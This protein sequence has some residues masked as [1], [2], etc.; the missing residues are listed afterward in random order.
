MSTVNRE[1]ERFDIRSNSIDF[2]DR[3]LVELE[4]RTYEMNRVFH[5]LILLMMQFQFV[6]SIKCDSRCGFK[7]VEQSGKNGRSAAQFFVPHRVHCCHR[8]DYPRLDR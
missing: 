8:T 6:D 4:L 5:L 3:L 7:I 2:V 1:E